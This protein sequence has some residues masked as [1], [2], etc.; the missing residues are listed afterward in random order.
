MKLSMDDFLE[1]YP[2]GGWMIHIRL[3]PNM[4]ITDRIGELVSGDWTFR[5]YANRG[6]R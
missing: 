6:V 4:A 1:Y 2:R 3:V 5:V